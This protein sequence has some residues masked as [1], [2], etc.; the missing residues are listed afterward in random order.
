LIVICD[1][2][3]GGNVTLQL[4]RLQPGLAGRLVARD[5][6]TGAPVTVAPDGSVQFKIRRHD[7]RI[8]EIEALKA[9]L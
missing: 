6:E 5:D 4:P 8:I 7:Y 9:G 3:D 1:Y 2:G